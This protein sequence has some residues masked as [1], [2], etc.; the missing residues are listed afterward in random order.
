MC[1]EICV[2]RFNFISLVIDWLAESCTNLNC[3]P[4]LESNNSRF[5]PDGTWSRYFWLN[6]LNLTVIIPSFGVTLEFDRVSQVEPQAS[7]FITSIFGTNGPLVHHRARLRPTR[8][9]LSFPTGILDNLLSGM[10]SIA[11][12]RPSNKHQG[13]PFALETCHSFIIRDDGELFLEATGWHTR[14]CQ[15][16]TYS[17]TRG[18]QGHNDSPQSSNQC[19]HSQ[20]IL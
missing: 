14:S 3:P 12:V 1:A 8:F 6:F 10:Y 11:Y 7:S 9:K 5:V 4:H 17:L 16:E 13:R 18:N 15:L 20:D 2:L 19:I